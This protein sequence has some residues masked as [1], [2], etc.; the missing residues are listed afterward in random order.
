MANPTKMVHN[1]PASGTAVTEEM[2]RAINP[3]IWASKLLLY[4]QK[5]IAKLTILLEEESGEQFTAAENMTLY[6]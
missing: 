6:T 4:L 5:G 1:L 2:S 3:S